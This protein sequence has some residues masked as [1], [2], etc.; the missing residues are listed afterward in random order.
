MKRLY[1]ILRG[2]GL[3]SAAFIQSEPTSTTGG[4]VVQGILKEI[5]NSFFV[6][7]DHTCKEQ[8]V[9]VD[10]STMII[11]KVQPGAQVKAEV[12]KDGY[13]SAVKMV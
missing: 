4:T 11:G 10:M 7:L 6:L 3:A 1:S 2:F 5:D 13:A 12:A 9:P 8:R